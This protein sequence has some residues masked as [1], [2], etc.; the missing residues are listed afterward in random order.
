MRRTRSLSCA[1]AATGHATAGPPSSVINSRRLT[2]SPEAGLG[3]NEDGLRRGPHSA[4]EAGFNLFFH[5]NP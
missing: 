1:R 5:S 3:S 4:G 2:Q